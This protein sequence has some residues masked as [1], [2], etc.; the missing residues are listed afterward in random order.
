MIQFPELSTANHIR[1]AFFT[2]QGGVSEGIFNSLNCGYGSDDKRDAVRENRRRVAREMAVA[3]DALITVY[4]VHSPDVVTVSETWAPEDAPKADAMV[5][6]RPGIALGILTADCAP[7]LFVDPEAEVVGAAH[8][9]WRG[10]VGGVT[11]ATIDAMCALGAS[12]ERIHTAIGP[13]IGPESYE[14]GA[15]FRDR[16]LEEGAA[17]DRYFRPG[18]RDG[19]FMFDLPGY[20]GDRLRGRGVATVNGGV[21]DTLPDEDRYFSYRRTTLRGEADYGR[22]IAAIAIGE[23]R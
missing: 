3:D 2:R 14:V 20:V 6:D 12:V 9:G 18:E 16:F 23:R 5:T 22:M 10:A 11:D 19:K 13:C 1:H 21:H 15:E 17:N 8:A 4:Q 7:V